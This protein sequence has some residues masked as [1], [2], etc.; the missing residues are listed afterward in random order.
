M[1]AFNRTILVEI[2]EG[3][4]AN[5]EGMSYDIMW[6]ICKK[7]R[8]ENLNESA[9]II[10]KMMQKLVAKNLFNHQITYEGIW[11]IY[12]YLIAKDYRVAADML[13]FVFE[14]LKAKGMATKP[15]LN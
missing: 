9:E 2:L 3:L 15:E 11:D 6:D 5:Y 13:R 10:D 7:L 4:D 12:K 8:E 14:D 1:P